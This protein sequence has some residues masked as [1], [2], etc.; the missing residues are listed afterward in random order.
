MVNRIVIPAA[1]IAAVDIINKE[2]KRRKVKV[3]QIINIEHAGY[4]IIVWYKDK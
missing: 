4:D 3:E 2:L 1:T